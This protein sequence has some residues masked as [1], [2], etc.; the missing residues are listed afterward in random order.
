MFLKIIP[1]EEFVC[2]DK[3]V[4]LDLTSPDWQAIVRQQDVNKPRGVSPLSYIADLIRYNDSTGQVIVVASGLFL[5]ASAVSL[6]AGLCISAKKEPSIVLEGQFFTGTIEQELIQHHDVVRL[7]LYNG[8]D[9]VCDFD[10]SSWNARIFFAG[11]QD[12]QKE[13][14]RD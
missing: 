9:S 1:L 8:M 5:V 14:R 6:T 13:L 12:Q 7:E 3:L 11:Q 4:A 2:P 10:R